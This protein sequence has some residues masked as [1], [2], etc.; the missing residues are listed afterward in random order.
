MFLLLAS[1]AHATLSSD[2]A[3]ATQ[4]PW[5]IGLSSGAGFRLLDPRSVPSG[6]APRLDVFQLEVRH[7][8]SPNSR[9]SQRLAAASWS[10]PPQRLDLQLN[11]VRFATTLTGTTSA[12]LPLTA[13]AT[14]LV[15]F[16]RRHSV[17]ISPG[18][19]AELGRDLVVVDQDLRRRPNAS[20]A[21]AG[22]IGLEKSRFWWPAST[23]G[24]YLQGLVGTAPSLDPN[25]RFSEREMSF[26]VQYS[27]A[28]GFPPPPK[29]AR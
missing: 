27:V 5:A 13:Y 15:P 3:G 4:R 19:S 8:L 28:F 12:R 24:L 17:A 26:A 20:L 1:V 6:L 10:I 14:W 21:I 11:T 9:S 25:H 7:T 23:S 2:Y 18:M 22:R 29:E 16:W